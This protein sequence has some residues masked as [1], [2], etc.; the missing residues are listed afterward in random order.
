METIEYLQNPKG[1]L[2][3]IKNYTGDIMNFE[4]AALRCSKTGIKVK[5]LV[6]NDDIAFIEKDPERK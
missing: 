1:L 4:S 3:I 2:L 6:V 5:T